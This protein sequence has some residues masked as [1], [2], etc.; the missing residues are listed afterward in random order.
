MGETAM[1]RLTPE[2]NYIRFRY[3]AE[4]QGELVAIFDV[5]RMCK[6][7]PFI[8]P[9]N[10]MD[11]SDGFPRLVVPAKD[12]DERVKKLDELRS[13]VH[14]M[15]TCYAEMAMQNLGTLYLSGA[16]DRHFNQ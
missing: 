5:H 14:P 9:E 6:K 8:T 10:Q 3:L 12:L 13:R 11:Y 1:G 16:L 2:E 4:R 15:E 7:K